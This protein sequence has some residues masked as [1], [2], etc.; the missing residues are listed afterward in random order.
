MRFH[1]TPEQVPE[2]IRWLCELVGMERFL[3]IIDNYG[4]EFLY[5]PKRETLE[6]PLRRAA[7]LR[8]FDGSNLLQLARKYGITERRIRAILREEGR[9]LHS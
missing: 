3:Q 8:D 1:L 9:G 2:D 4:G 5:F 6:K 7:I